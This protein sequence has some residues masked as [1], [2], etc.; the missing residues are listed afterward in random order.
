MA[1]ERS[2][3]VVLQALFRAVDLDGDGTITPTELEGWM[4]ATLDDLSRTHSQSSEAKMSFINKLQADLKNVEAISFDEFVRLADDFWDSRDHFRMV[5][6]VKN[7][8]GS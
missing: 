3:R 8:G 4:T 7:Q 2:Q 5:K 1:A 6:G